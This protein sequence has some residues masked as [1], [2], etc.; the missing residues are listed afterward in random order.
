MTEAEWLACEDPQKL[1]NFL[2]RN[3][4]ERKVPLFSVACCRR[5]WLSLDPECQTAVDSAERYIDGLASVGEVARSR[6]QIASRLDSPARAAASAADLAQHAV[7]AARYVVTSASWV[8]AEARIP[9]EL[10]KV[11]GA[12]NEHWHRQKQAV[13]CRDENAAQAHLL[14]HIIGNPFRPYH[15]P[16]HWPSTTVQLAQTL[17]NCQD[18]SFALHDALL[19]AGHP[20]L[21]K[22][23]QEEHLHPKG[24]WVM[25]LLLGKE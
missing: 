17:Y 8:A 20:E 24:C 5:I 22:H 16:D 1:L 7:E 19:E 13:A 3:A 4:S 9:A 23:F 14:R 10:A 25:D 12:A 21:A 18:C 15:I 2:P 6:F 11:G